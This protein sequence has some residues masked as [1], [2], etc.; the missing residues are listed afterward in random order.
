MIEWWMNGMPVH[1]QN[2]SVERLSMRRVAGME[3]WNNAGIGDLRFFFI[4][5]F[6]KLLLLLESV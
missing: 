4:I 1:V 3:W 2:N 5:S 6:F